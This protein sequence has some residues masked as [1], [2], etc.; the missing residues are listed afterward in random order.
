M[1]FPYLE[2]MGF[3]IR[4]PH[5]QKTH[6]PRTLPLAYESGPWGALRGWGVSYGRDTPVR[7]LTESA[8]TAL[9]TSSCMPTLAAVLSHGEGGSERETSPPPRFLIMAREREGV[10]VR[11]CVYVCVLA[12]E[13]EG[14]CVCERE[15]ARRE[16]EREIES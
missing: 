6:P 3:Q 1:G 4:V 14:V 9:A 2:N 10:C 7:W 15:R 13:R 5:T 16:R 12:R 11:V 8:R